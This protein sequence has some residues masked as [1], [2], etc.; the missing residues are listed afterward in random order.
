MRRSLNNRQKGKKTFEVICDLIDAF[1][2][3]HLEEVAVFS[4]SER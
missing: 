2:Y 1:Y 3:M 4:K